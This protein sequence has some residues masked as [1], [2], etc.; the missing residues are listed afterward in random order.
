[1][2]VQAAGRPVLH[3][4]HSAPPETAGPQGGHRLRPPRAPAGPRPHRPGRGRSAA[5]GLP[6]LQRRAHRRAGGL[7]VPRRPPPTPGDRDLPLRHPD[8][9]LPAV[10]ATR[11]VTSPRADLTSVGCGRRPGRATRG[12]AGGMGVQGAGPADG[13]GRPAARP[14]RR[15]HHP[16]WGDP[17]AG[18]GG[19]PLAADLC[20][21]GRW[22][23]GQPDRRPG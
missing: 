9:P 11:P 14:A 16:W 6:A 21:A 10:P 19:A 12:R 1:M 15:H 23:A 20:R 22:R 7:P 13:Q 18:A 8:R 3:G 17:G 4:H 2:G 5:G